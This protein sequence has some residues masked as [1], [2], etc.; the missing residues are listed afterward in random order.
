MTDER[1]IRDRIERWAAAH[2]GDMTTV[3][4]DHAPG[5]S[6]ALGGVGQINLSATLAS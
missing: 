5:I 2:A 4:A 6:R 3:P 1:Q